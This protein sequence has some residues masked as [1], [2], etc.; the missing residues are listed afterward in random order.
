MSQLQ[1]YGAAR[2]ERLAARIT[3][4]TI[5][6]GAGWDFVR[7]MVWGAFRAGER[8]IRKRVPVPFLTGWFTR[9]AEGLLTELVGPEPS[10]LGVMAEEG[11]VAD[12]T[13]LVFRGRTPEPPKPA[14]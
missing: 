11:V 2:A 12:E 10:D 5:P 1:A 9:W 14:A 3:G 6:A 8:I 7:Y 13:I 4:L